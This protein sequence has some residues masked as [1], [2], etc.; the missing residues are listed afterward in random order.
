MELKTKTISSLRAY[1]G[2]VHAKR[3]VFGGN[4]IFQKVFCLFVSFYVCLFFG[5]AEHVE[6]LW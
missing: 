5:H 2:Y 4:V 1:F 3:A 6:R